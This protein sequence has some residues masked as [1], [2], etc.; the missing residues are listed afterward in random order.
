MVLELL[1]YGLEEKLEAREYFSPSAPLLRNRFIS[2]VGDG[3]DANP[4]LLSK[5]VKLDER[6]AA[7]LLNSDETDPKIASFST[8][9]KPVRSFDDLIVPDDQK[10]CLLEAVKRRI[11]EDSRFMS[12]YHIFSGLPEGTYTLS[13]DSEF[14]F[15]EEKIVDTSSFVNSKEPVVEIVL[16]PKPLYPFPDR[17]TLIRGL[18]SP[19]APDPDLFAGITVK[20][21]SKSTGRDI[22]GTPDEKG[23]FVLY[24][25]EIIPRKADIILEI[26]GEE[27]EK[28]LS[29]LIEEGQSVYTGVISIP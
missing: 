17:A 13:V 26:K 24:F 1:C 27:I 16:K 15:S 7:F 8:L 18:L 6:I 29:V 21:T 23:E 2:L 22:R 5:F 25:R 12:G 3:T 14:Y 10:N 19:L 9:V 20:A 4:P 11:E 28:T